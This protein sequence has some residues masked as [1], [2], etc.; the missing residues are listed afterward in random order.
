[1]LRLKAKAILKDPVHSIA[2]YLINIYCRRAARNEADRLNGKWD[3]ASSTKENINIEARRERA[4]F[5]FYLVLRNL[6]YKFIEILGVLI[7]KKPHI[8]VFAHHSIASDGWRFSVK[9][10]EFEQQINHLL[11]THIPIK[12][13]ELPAYI[14]GA[15]KPEKNMF[16]LAFDD[17]YENIIKVKDFLKEKG[18]TPVFFLIADNAQADFSKLSDSKLIDEISES[19][20][21]LENKLGVPVRYFAYPKG[22][23]GTR[24]REAVRDAGYDLGFSMDNGYVVEGIDRFAIPRVGVDGTHRL[25]QFKVIYFPVAMMMRKI[26]WKS[27]S[28][29]KT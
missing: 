5:S 22:M 2:I 28:L 9:K 4:G 10:E 18:S 16:V 15:K 23:Y 17:G 14:S 27:L 20:K 11:K 24:I 13:S 26:I 1:M 25:N 19:K 3:I 7:P 8:V 21:I 12:A 6:V 29:L